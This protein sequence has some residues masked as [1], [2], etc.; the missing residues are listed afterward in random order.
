MLNKKAV[1]LAVLAT[2]L[3]PVKS[4]STVCWWNILYPQLNSSVSE[5]KSTK[6]IVKIKL[7]ELLENK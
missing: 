7:L 1:T 4:T 6:P 5:E 3:M 2:L